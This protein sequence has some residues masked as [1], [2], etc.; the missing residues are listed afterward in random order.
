MVPLYQ[1]ASKAPSLEQQDTSIE[2]VLVTSNYS[3]YSTRKTIDIVSD[4][5]GDRTP[6]ATTPS[7][8]PSPK[9]TGRAGRSKLSVPRIKVEQQTRWLSHGQPAANRNAC[10]ARS[11]T[12]AVGKRERGSSQTYLASVG[13]SFSRRVA[14][15]ATL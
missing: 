13:R 11:E 7:S 10:A 8:H 6:T 1:R 15:F 12:S 3:I 4:G 2:D 5:S 9:S 14:R